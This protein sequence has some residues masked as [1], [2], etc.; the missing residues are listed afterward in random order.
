MSRGRLPVAEPG[1]VLR[2]VGELVAT[3]L[4]ARDTERNVTQEVAR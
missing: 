3:D 2:T 4:A 1:D